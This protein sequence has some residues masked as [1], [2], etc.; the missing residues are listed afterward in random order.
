LFNKVLDRLNLF[1]MALDDQHGWDYE[2]DETVQRAIEATTALLAR[3]DLERLHDTTS[4]MTERV[5]KAI[6]AAQSATPKS[7][8]ANKE[9]VPAKGKEFW[10]PGC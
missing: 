2:P 9:S 10:I 6:E 1:D 4:H 3:A 5:W 7:S 8:R